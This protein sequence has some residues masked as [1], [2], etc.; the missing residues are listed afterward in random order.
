MSN[1]HHKDLARTMALCKAYEMAGNV[2]CKACGLPATTAH[3][4]M[5]TEAARL[6][7]FAHD[8]YCDACLPK[9]G[10][11]KEISAAKAIRRLMRIA[12]GE[13]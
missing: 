4:T 9:E 13:T 5:V 7:M 6:F 10:A 1:D 11:S 3:S 2:S 12:K 8:A